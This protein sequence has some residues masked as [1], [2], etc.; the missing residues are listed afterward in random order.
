MGEKKKGMFYGWYIV[1]SCFFALFVVYGARYY[2][3]G[4][5]FKP[6]SKEFGWNRTIVSSAFTLS[7]ILYGLSSPLIGKTVD[8]FGAKIVMILGAIIGGI[9]FML[10]YFTESLIHFYIFYSVIM[11]IGMAA[12][13][14]VPT[15]AV[16]AKWFTKKR[17]T[18]MGIISIGVAIGP[19]II[20]NLAE[21]MVQNYGWR[22]SFV[23]MGVI[24]LALLLPVIAF[25]IKNNP[26]EMG[27]LPDGE[28]V[29][30][31]KVSSTAQVAT[32]KA[33][34]VWTMKGAIAT[35]AFWCIS[36][37]YFFFLFLYN[38]I[39][40]HIIP[41]ATDIG[42]PRTVA[43]FAMSL[44][45]AFSIGG[46][47][48]GGRLGDMFPIKNV[49]AGSII[50]ELIVMIIFPN[51]TGVK[52]V[53]LLYAFTSLFGFAYG[54][55]TPLVSAVT[56]STFGPKSFGVIYGGVLMVAT[57]GNGAGP[58]VAGIIYDITKSYYWVFLGGCIM[59]AISAVLIYVLRPPKVRET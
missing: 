49:L 32:P 2:S 53:A 3:F 43:A 52:Q 18:A 34:P 17:S 38:I 35:P 23:M 57:I 39:I 58:L 40:V 59:L 30:P 12:T 20:I 51:I 41:Y 29:T 14:L 36:L 15:N 25:F 11:T 31:I 27:L 6:L 22:L 24:V 48:G 33:E 5:F 7:T 26:Q 21:W 1:A 16:I 45:M 56:A 9:G 13:A 55:V 4:V 44:L 8:R 46:R 54:A 42:H 28:V 19:F 50:L 47:L 10:I 37:C